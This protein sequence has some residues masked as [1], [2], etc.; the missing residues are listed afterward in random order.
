MTNTDTRPA[1]SAA[2]LEALL[3][4][5]T[6]T[7]VGASQNAAPSRHLMANLLA[8][9][10][11]KFGGHVN[12]INRSRP[13]LYGHR[14]LPSTAQ[15]DGDP[16]LVFLLI[17]SAHCLDALHGLPRLPQGVVVYAN[18]AESGFAD[19]ERD[20]RVWSLD[21][22]VPL[23]GPQA[24]GIVRPDR[25]LVALTAPL[26]A[27]PVSGRLGLLMQSAGLLGGTLNALWQRE[28][29]VHTA[30]SLGNSAVLGYADL[31]RHLVHQDDIGAIAM[32]LDSLPGMDDLIDVACRA[33]RVDKPI[34]LCVGG[35]S[36][37]GSA[38]VQSHTGAL[39]ASHRVLRGVADQYGI[40]L[41]DDTDELVWAIE[42]FA[43]MHYQRPSPGGV[44]IFSTSG[45]GA[46]MLAD[47]MS[48]YH[49]R[50]PQPGPE[51]RQQ[52]S[53]KRHVVSFNPFDVGAAALD[54]PEEVSNAAY[55]F[56]ADPAFSVV[57]SVATVGLPTRTGMEAHV[58]QT[59]SLVAGVLSAGKQ[60]MIASPVAGAPGRAGAPVVT[61][62]NVV[63][64]Q[65]SKE[66]AVKARSVCAWG[67]R[68]SIADAPQRPTSTVPAAEAADPSPI[69]IRSGA[70]AEADLRSLAVRWPR[71][72]TVHSEDEIDA[73]LSD[74]R[75][76]A[77]AKAEAGLAHRAVNG[78][79]IRGLADARTA[80]LATQYLLTRFEAPVV[81]VE[82]ITFDQELT[83]GFQ[84]DPRNG[85][86]LMFGHGG[87]D[88]G[89]SV[90]FRRLPMT[91]GQI[92]DLVATYVD[93][94]A[95]R[96]ALVRTLESFQNHVLAQPRTVSLDL[97]P[98]VVVDRTV[99]ALDA[100]IHTRASG[101]GNQPQA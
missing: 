61:W 89:E 68:V 21:T 26:R 83:L 55:T 97:N 47:A 91:D 58:Q 25:G 56:A 1:F 65:G 8:D 87:G 5:D 70:A 54:D 62:D 86:L 50:L 59:T 2:R 12:L 11:G 42:A 82:Q 14:A 100:K 28:I 88:V 53:R 72:H 33:Q 30:V 7:I 18:G 19:V 77:V 63:I 31:A 45:G 17:G 4:P 94:P 3:S 80:T 36:D 48:A 43:Q 41:V 90:D 99:W 71:A 27:A 38:A 92:A 67:T 76:P 69:V 16:G 29:G 95:D 66:A 81:L 93:E 20:L 32:Y 79:V 52:L 37:A 6:V 9:G 34:V 35:S 24:T 73:A 51:T 46:I 44:G 78:G 98:I 15:V 60:P 39:A 49:A 74:L 13:T 85:P 64:A 101:P 23:L 57:V 10:P 75:L 40:V 84:N 96:A 22:G